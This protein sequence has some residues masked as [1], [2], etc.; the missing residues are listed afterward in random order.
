MMI[1]QTGATQIRAAFPSA[2]VPIVVAAYMAGLKVVFA[3]IVGTF[4]TAFLV[5]LFAKW[6]RL[7]APAAKNGDRR[8]VEEKTASPQ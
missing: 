2:Q 3:F 7:Q 4:G 5:S 8:D 1:L 6:E